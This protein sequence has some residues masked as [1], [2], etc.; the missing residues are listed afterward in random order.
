MEV[1]EY[2]LANG[3][4]VNADIDGATALHWAAW[5]A[6]PRMVEFLIRH[7]ADTSSKDR[8]HNSTPKEW[9]IHRQQQLGPRW[10]HPDVIEL[11]DNA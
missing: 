2:L 5:E 4:D 3:L 8:D 9:A 1:V 10:G 11:L 7:G 6:K